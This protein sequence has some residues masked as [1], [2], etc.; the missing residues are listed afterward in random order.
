MSIAA[1]S[2][3]QLGRVFC[4]SLT[5]ALLYRLADRGHLLLRRPPR[6]K[7]RRD[8]FWALREISFQVEPGECLGIIGPNGAGKSTLLKL[9]NRE[10]RPT[11]GQIATQ[12]SMKSLI[13]IGAGLQPMLSGRENIYVQCAQLGLNTRQTDSVVTG[14]V[15][16][17]EL[18]EAI[19][20][21]VKT[22]SDG[23]YARLEFAIAT[24]I[25]TDLLLVDEVLAVGDVAFQLRALERLNRLKREGT[26]IIFVS[27]SEM[28][29]RQVA[30][31]CLLLFAGRQVALGEPDA[32]FYRYYASIGYLNQALKPLGA[33]PPLPA[34]L[35]DD[36][37][38]TTAGVQ[39]VM[40]P[41]G[42]V[43]SGE[44]FELALSLNSRRNI[45]AAEIILQFWNSAGI[46]VATAK[47]G[48]PSRLGLPPGNRGVRVNLRSLPLAAGIYRV[49]ASLRDGDRLVAQAGRLAEILVT[50][51]G[52]GP[53]G[54]LIVLDAEIRADG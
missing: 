39:T 4:R 37:R 54:G 12:G 18:E 46:L 30:D 51:P 15:G 42:R 50:E 7:L 6:K 23:M 53:A 44:P 2:V 3:H 33:A 1:V 5:S 34:D 10:L 19:D 20:A 14:I 36:V 28:N 31:R 38:I 45:Q 9:I 8:E 24:S 32:L 29:V 35:A 52:N 41:E 11:T 48:I 47:P 17:A 43:L 40:G 21:P 49:S 22:Y 13:R 16:F 26:A 27:H 25:R